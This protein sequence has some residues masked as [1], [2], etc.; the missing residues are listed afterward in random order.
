MARGTALRGVVR[1]SFSHGVDPG[2]PHDRMTGM[3]RG[4]LLGASLL[5]D[6]GCVMRSD[7]RTIDPG[8]GAAGELPL[9]CR[10][11]LRA[12][13]V[14]G[15]GRGPRVCSRSAPGASRWNRSAYLPKHFSEI[16]PHPAR[17]E[18]PTQTHYLPQHCSAGAISCAYT[19]SHG[20]ARPHPSSVC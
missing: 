8:A 17:P 19:L 18:I 10:A 6:L 9:A 2:S 12:V 3:T 20:W 5:Y 11:A 15:P 7:P 13:A 4:G 14:V 16:H 1:S